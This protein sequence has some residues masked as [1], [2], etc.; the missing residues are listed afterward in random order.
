MWKII[1]QSVFISL[2]LFVVSFLLYINVM[3]LTLN[4]TATEIFE[5]SILLCLLI[6][7]HSL[8]SVFIIVGAILLPNIS[9][10][11]K[12]SLIVSIIYSLVVFIPP[13]VC[14]LYNEAYLQKDLSRSF[15]PV[16]VSGAV[17]IFISMALVLCLYFF[18]KTIK[19]NI[20][21]IIYDISCLAF[22]AASYFFYSLKNDYVLYILF[23]QNTVGL[24]MAKWVE[25]K[26]KKRV[27]K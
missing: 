17:T 21:I 22:I 23:F 9:K 7:Y 10:L 15:Q 2:F 20:L 8:L 1:L 12:N 6:F 11:L 13:I 4:N 18:C 14:F 16:L 3:G 24:F 26:L 5:W 27:I 19:T 25:Y